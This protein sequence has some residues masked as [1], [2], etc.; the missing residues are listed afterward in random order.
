[1]SRTSR[2]RKGQALHGWLILDKPSGLTS[3]QALGAVKRLLLPRKA[4]HAGTLDPLA[5]GILPIALGEATKTAQFV[6]EGEKVYRF[7]VRWGIETDTDDA[8][9]AARETS[10]L[11]PQ[12]AEI[13]ALLPCFTGE[14]L[15]VP[16]Q[17]SAVKVGGERAYGLARAGET[18]PLAPRRI[19][20]RELHL[21]ALPNPDT[22]IFETRCGK[23]TYVRA[24]ARDMGRALGCFGHVSELR[25]TRVGPFG[26]DAAVP[27][28]ELCKRVGSGEDL[29]AQGLIKPVESALSGLLA[30]EVSAADAAD[31]AMGRAVLIRGRDAPILGGM[32]Y[33]TCK[34]R[35]TALGE[36]SKS[37]FHPHRVFTFG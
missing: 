5:A 2:S 12:E 15:Q 34:G 17:F 27:L 3:N 16:P 36:V 10:A 20:I 37:A 22:A 6:T 31:I 19:I 23:G 29:L 14:I 1:M 18:V 25:R 13:R 28:G 30:L 33:A 7:S 4:G 24:L 26:E 8:E 11:R 9:G 32:A 35:L 21:V